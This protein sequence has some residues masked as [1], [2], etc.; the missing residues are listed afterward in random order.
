[1]NA[2]KVEFVSERKVVRTLSSIPEAQK[3][4]ETLIRVYN[5]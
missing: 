1:M 5:K 2:L 3:V 4:M